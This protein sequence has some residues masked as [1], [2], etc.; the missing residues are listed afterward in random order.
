MTFKSRGSRLKGSTQYL[1]RSIMSNTPPELMKFFNGKIVENMT[2]WQDRSTEILKYF[3]NEVYG[4][5]PYLHCKTKLELI[6]EGNVSDLINCKREQYQLKIIFDKKEISVNILVYKP[7]HIPVKAT[8]LGLIFLGNQTVS[9]DKNIRIGNNYVRNYNVIDSYLKENKLGESSRGIRA[10]SY[11]IQNIVNQGFSLM[12]ACHGDICPDH[13]SMYLKEGAFPLCNSKGEEANEWGA[14]SAWAWGLSQ[15][16]NHVDEIKSLNSSK[17]ILFGHSRLGKT[18]LWSAA[19]DQRIM[20]VI[21]NQSGCL[22]AKLHA[23]KEGEKFSDIQKNF[24]HWFCKKFYGYQEETLKVDQHCLLALMA[25]RP[26][27]VASAEEDLWCDPTGQFTALQM[28]QPAYN[29]YGIKQTS[30]AKEPKVDQPVI[31]WLAYHNRKGDHSLKDYDWTQY[32]KWADKISA[33][34]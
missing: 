7:L 14:I 20:G 21:A 27:Y 2:D 4:L 33:I 31:D 1:E 12:T 23:R 6:E 34:K 17:V 26:V 10:S 8:F 15:I 32:M 13:E 11:P 24:P 29:L 25:P 22:G 30:L 18:A 16:V 5:P 28:S 3:Q 19:Q 9:F